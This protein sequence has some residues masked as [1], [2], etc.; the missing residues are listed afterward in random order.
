[1]D[2]IRELEFGGIDLPRYRR[3]AGALNDVRAR[4][5]FPDDFGLLAEPAVRSHAPAA[6]PPAPRSPAEQDYRT[7]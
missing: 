6:A 5:D 7:G 1:M 4:F 3:Q 2:G